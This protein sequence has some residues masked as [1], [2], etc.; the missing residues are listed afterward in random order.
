[1]LP[2]V[3]AELE[4]AE[5]EELVL[6]AHAIGFQIYVCELSGDAGCAWNLKMPEAVL[7]DDHGNGIGTHFAGPT[8]RLADGS[9]INAKVVARAQSPDAKAIP[10]LLLTVTG[11]EGDGALARVSTI[12]RI[13]T[14]GGMAP[15]ERGT[16]GQEAKV[17]YSA[18]YYFYGARL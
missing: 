6:K 15:V 17:F 8:W 5:G 11:R 3:P 4:V 10:W 18:D 9:R 13:H 16:L 12:Q 1:M 7:F 14:S 2:A